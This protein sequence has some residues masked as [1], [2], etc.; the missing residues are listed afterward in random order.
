MP[1]SRD[2]ATPGHAHYACTGTAASGPP[3]GSPAGLPAGQWPA[4]WEVVLRLYASTNVPGWSSGK[5]NSNF[6][7]LGIP[8]P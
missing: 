1:R 4:R 5:I 6:A 3:A 7:C 8:Q 2:A